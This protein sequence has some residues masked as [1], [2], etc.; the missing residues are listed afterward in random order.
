MYNLKVNDS[1]TLTQIN[2]GIFTGMFLPHNNCKICIKVG[3]NKAYGK[4]TQFK[5]Y[6][7]N[8]H[9]VIQHTLQS[10]TNLQQN[11]LPDQQ[12]LK[13]TQSHFMSTS[14]IKYFTELVL[15]VNY[16]L[17]IKLLSMR[18]TVTKRK[19][20]LSLLQTKPKRNNRK[21]Y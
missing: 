14:T 20:T 2:F 5:C 13:N 16:F 21:P 19:T 8:M 10:N 12:R 15:Y 4:Q 18:R 6:C 3:L 1:K 11:H 7:L 9:S 17:P